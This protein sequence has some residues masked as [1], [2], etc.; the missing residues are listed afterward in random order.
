MNNSLQFQSEVKGKANKAIIALHGWQGNRNSFRFL[1]GLMKVDD[2]EW[3]FPE[4]PYVLDGNNETR[5]WSYEISPGIWE[6][7]EPN[8]LLSDFFKNEVFT[9]YQSEDV[10][11]L[12]FSQGAIICYE[13]ALH[14]ETKLGGIFP[15]AGMF[16]KKDA[17]KP[18]F[19]SKQKN[20][21]VIIGHG[22]NDKVVD[23][24][25]SK[26]IFSILNKQ[27]AN[28]RLLEF[29]G[30]HKISLEYLKEITKL[31]NE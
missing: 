23:I 12:G 10:F 28:V 22:T 27:G 8:R 4:A 7:N 24:D 15:I 21:P 26:K 13:F 31:I 1:A 9:K 3:F 29:N 17:D 2:V 11:I 25:Y 19:H 14:L 30:G 16:R 20:T 6:F 5:S 18:R